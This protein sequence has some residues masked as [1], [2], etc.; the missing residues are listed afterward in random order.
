MKTDPPPLPGESEPHP[1][2]G[3]LRETG[4]ASACPATG[5]ASAQSRRCRQRWEICFTRVLIKKVNV[6]ARFLTISQGNNRYRQ[7]EN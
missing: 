3:G 7:G 5:E 6:G 2:R 4:K 1:W